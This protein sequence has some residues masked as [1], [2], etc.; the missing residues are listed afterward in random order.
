MKKIPLDTQKAVKQK[1]LKRIAA[2]EIRFS[3]LLIGFSGG[4][5][6]ANASTHWHDFNGFISHFD[7][8]IFVLT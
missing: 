3:R 2:M 4:I 1:T 8:T 5:M 6:K 7:F